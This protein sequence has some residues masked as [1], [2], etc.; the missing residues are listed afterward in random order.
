[1]KTDYLIGPDELRQ[2]VEIVRKRFR[3]L[4]VPLAPAAGKDMDGTLLWEGTGVD[5]EMI[6][7]HGHEA[8]RNLLERCNNDPNNAGAILHGYL[9]R[10]M[11]TAFRLGEIAAANKLASADVEQLQELKAMIDSLI[12]TVVGGD[13]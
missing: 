1:M 13:E 5:A 12:A 10:E 3:E 4:E 9:Q 11:L 2:A 6:L 8:V 7:T